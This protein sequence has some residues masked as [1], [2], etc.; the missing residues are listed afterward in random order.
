MKKLI[1]L[2]VSALS[3]ITISCKKEVVEPVESSFLIETI[4]IGNWN[5]DSQDGLIVPINNSNNIISIDVLIY[6][7]N[8]NQT[9]LNQ[10]GSFITEN[11][12]VIVFRYENG[13]FDQTA[14]SNGSIN[15]GIITIHYD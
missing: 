9:P 4:N 15:R 7:D 8:G 1:I 5:M 2:L 10:A 13:Y 3:F 14:F 6:S 12:S 11:E